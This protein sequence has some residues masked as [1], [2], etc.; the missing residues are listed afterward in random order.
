MSSARVCA[1]HPV[2]RPPL[3][4]IN[5]RHM[6]TSLPHEVFT[7]LQSACLLDDVCARRECVRTL[8]KYDEC[9]VNATGEW[10][11]DTPLMLGARAHC[12]SHM[13]RLVQH[14]FGK[15]TRCLMCCWRI[16]K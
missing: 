13:E 15:T 11:Q 12:W 4:N 5:A 7:P 10:Y 8:C 14:V 3:L 2:D 6:E 16:G 9:D 1:G